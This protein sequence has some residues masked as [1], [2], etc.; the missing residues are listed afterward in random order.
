MFYFYNCEI[1]L[2]CKQFVFIKEV[3]LDAMQTLTEEEIITI[4]ESEI[5]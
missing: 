5:C 2:Y 3:I 4:E 1:T